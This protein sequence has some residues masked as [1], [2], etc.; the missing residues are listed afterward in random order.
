VFGSE[1]TLALERGMPV[2]RRADGSKPELRELAAVNPYA[3]FA[4]A[5]ATR[6]PPPVSGVDGRE[7]LAIV[8]AAYESAA[9][10]ATTRVAHRK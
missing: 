9:G 7:A 2:V 3:A 4:E 1:G 6:T 8:L 10:G 5:C